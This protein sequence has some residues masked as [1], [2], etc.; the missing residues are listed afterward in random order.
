MQIDPAL[1]GKLYL[2]SLFLGLALGLLQ[3]AA[4]LLQVLFGAYP[5]PARLKELYERR[6]P[7][8]GRAVGYGD[9]LG[10]SHGRHQL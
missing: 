10:A 1:Q 6:L 5:K 9:R 2:Y 8:L 7:C 4:S 3:D